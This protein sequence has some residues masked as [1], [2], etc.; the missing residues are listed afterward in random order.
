MDPLG[1]RPQVVD[2]GDVLRWGAVNPETPPPLSPRDREPVH[3]ISPFPVREDLNDK[4]AL[5]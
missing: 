3:V 1:A 5:W 2:I 4:V